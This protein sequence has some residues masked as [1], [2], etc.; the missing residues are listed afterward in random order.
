MGTVVGALIVAG[1]NVYVLCKN[2]TSLLGN[3]SSGNPIV[4]VAF[5]T[6]TVFSIERLLNASVSFVFAI[7]VKVP[8]AL[9]IVVLFPL[10]SILANKE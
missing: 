4:G 9:F 10:A 8:L 3:I 6:V 5:L 7:I 2:N 1:E